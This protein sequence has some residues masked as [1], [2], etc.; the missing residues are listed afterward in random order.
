MQYNDFVAA[1]ERRMKLLIVGSRS[2]KEFDLAQHIPEG[3]HMIMTGGADGIDTLAEA[4]ADKNRL[5]K[6]ILRPQYDRFGRG[7]PLKRN[8]KLV[9]LCDLALVIWDGSSKGTAYTMK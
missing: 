4:Y 5:S 3:I 8:E 9:E 6:L 1:E 2:I 7:A